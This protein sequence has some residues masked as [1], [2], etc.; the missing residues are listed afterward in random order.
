MVEQD[1]VLLRPLK[2]FLKREVPIRVYQAVQRLLPRPVGALQ[3]IR[4]KAELTV[5]AKAELFESCIELRIALN[6]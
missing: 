6:H 1:K 3:R 5:G 4:R 2:S